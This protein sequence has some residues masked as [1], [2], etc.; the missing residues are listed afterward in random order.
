[1]RKSLCYALALILATT[2]TAHAAQTDTQSNSHSDSM[3]C[4]EFDKPITTHDY[5]SAPSDILHPHHLELTR[6]FAPSGKLKLHIC[7]ADLRINTRPDAKEIKLTVNLDTQSGSY[8]VAD[9]IQ[10]IRVQPDKGVINLNFPKA[11]HATVTVTLPMGQNSENEINLGY[12]DLDFNA[13]GSAGNREINVGMGHMQLIVDKDKNYSKMEVNVGM[14][15]LHDHRPGG[16][17]GHIV[18]SKDYAG[19][20]AGSLQINVGMGSLDIRND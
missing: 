2:L 17:D 11:A 6:P 13:I 7:R 15:S 8:T 20:G 1:M 14:G 9:Y 4:T 16:H 5:I 3:N 12:G 18:V 19:T 10:T